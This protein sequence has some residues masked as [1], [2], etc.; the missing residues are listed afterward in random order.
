MWPDQVSK[1]RPLALQSD[2]LPTALRSLARGRGPRRFRFHTVK[3]QNVFL[4]LQVI[5]YGAHWGF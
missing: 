4:L 1:P 3:G 5:V 2:A